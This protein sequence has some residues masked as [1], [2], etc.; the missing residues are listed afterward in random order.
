MLDWA[1]IANTMLTSLFGLGAVS[2]QVN[3]RQGG[4]ILEVDLSRFRIRVQSQ[5]G[6]RVTVHQHLP[7]HHTLESCDINM[8]WAVRE[9]R[10][11]SSHWCLNSFVSHTPWT[12]PGAG[13][14]LNE[15]A[16]L[17]LVLLVY[18]W[19][20]VFVEHTA[21]CKK[22]KDFI[23]L[24]S[25]QSSVTSGFFTY[26]IFCTSTHRI[27][28]NFSKGSWPWFYFI[29]FVFDC[30]GSLSLHTGFLRLRGAGASL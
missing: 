13:H 7:G 8:V 4:L 29:L 22:D 30:S 3:L 21:L 5:K 14:M 1:D 6:C 27:T 12:R 16:R 26:H 18:R 24:W 11:K 20:F 23:N 10:M 28:T 2:T 19:F 17:E 9:F 15:Y 25:W